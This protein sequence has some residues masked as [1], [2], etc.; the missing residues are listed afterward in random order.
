MSE[1]LILIFRFH[2]DSLDHWSDVVGGVVFELGGRI[3]S[4]PDPG[5]VEIVAFFDVFCTPLAILKR[6]LRAE[7]WLD[8]SQSASLSADSDCSWFVRGV[9]A[10]ADCR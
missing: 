2:S 1:K 5:L 8:Q 9:V 6:H 7:L 10:R 4:V 3:E